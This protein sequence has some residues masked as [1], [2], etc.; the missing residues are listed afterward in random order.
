MKVVARMIAASL[1]SWAVVA[2]MVDPRARVATL[3]GMAG[4]LV[5]VGV[6]W[7]LAE[8]VWRS[9]PE[10]LTRLMVSAFGGKMVFFGAYVTVMLAGFSLEPVAFVVS[11]TAYF[12]ALYSIEALLLKRLVRFGG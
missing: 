6:S 7:V 10:D 12:I 3:A 1:A 8:R 2:A 11:F 5:V 9:S 4:P